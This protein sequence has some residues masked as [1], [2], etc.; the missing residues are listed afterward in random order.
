MEVHYI[1]KFSHKRSCKYICVDNIGM[2]RLLLISAHT[3]SR[4]FL[5]ITLPAIA[6]RL[7]VHSWAQ[8]DTV[9]TQGAQLG[10][11]T[12]NGQGEEGGK[13]DEWRYSVCLP[14]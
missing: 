4:R 6:I 1:L 14:T 12:Q 10:Q 9:V 13:R 2:F 5:L 11:L 3:A 7:G 8:G